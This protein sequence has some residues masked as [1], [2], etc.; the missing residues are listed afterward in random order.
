MNYAGWYVLLLWVCFA[1]PPWLPPP[2]PLRLQDVR[3]FTYPAF[4]HPAAGDYR[5]RTSQLPLFN[6]IAVQ[7]SWAGRVPF[8]SNPGGL[9][10]WVCIILNL[11]SGS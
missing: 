3:S 1:S 11:F 5:V 10:F 6:D 8:E 7:D 9:F 2:T 4:A